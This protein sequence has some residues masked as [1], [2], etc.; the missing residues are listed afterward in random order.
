MPI[1]DDIETLE[2]QVQTI[3]EST[4]SYP[5]IENFREG[6]VDSILES[7]GDFSNEELSTANLDEVV[8]QALRDT[9]DFIDADLMDQIDRDVNSIVNN[10]MDFY[11]EQGIT[12]PNLGE[13]ITRVDEI[14]RLM[15]EFTENMGSMRDELLD[16]T[17]DTIKQHFAKGSVSRAGL[18]DDIF[19]A[20][21][22][23]LHHARTNARMVVSTYNRIGREQVRAEAG[24]QHGYYAGEIRTNSRA[25]CIRCIGRTFDM[26]QIARMSNGQGLDVKLY[27]GGWNCIHSWMWVEPEWDEQLKSR[28][29]AERDIVSLEDAGLKYKA[30]QQE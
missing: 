7:L 16:G 17:I 20:A 23:N 26:A 21:D 11:N 10:T 24:L 12:L 3:L 18:A 19:A 29:D 5:P 9:A 28:Y 30:P 6:Y 1:F 22:G 15:T 8:K 27:C 14:E 2:D 13:A 25:F 4:E